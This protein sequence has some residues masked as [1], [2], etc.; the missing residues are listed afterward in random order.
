M[1][2]GFVFN[3]YEAHAD[4]TGE[5]IIHNSS[6]LEAL[7]NTVGASFEPLDDD[8]CLFCPKALPEPESMSSL[9]QFET[10][11]S[12]EPVAAALR[13]LRFSLERNGLVADDPCVIIDKFRST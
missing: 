1:L 13:N 10:Y 4:L 7:A 11:L 8:L 12:S 6:H 3:I 5:E 2:I 9:K